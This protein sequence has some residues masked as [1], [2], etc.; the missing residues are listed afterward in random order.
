MNSTTLFEPFRLT[1]QIKGDLYVFRLP[2]GTSVVDVRPLL[3]R[4]L[5]EQ[6]ENE[7]SRI[8]PE[9]ALGGLRAFDSIDELSS[10]GH[11]M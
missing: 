4:W 9:D 7:Q 10:R 6:A 2:A 8:R 1:I 5:L 11:A 3:A